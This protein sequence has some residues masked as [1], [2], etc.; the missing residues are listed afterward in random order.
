MEA[1]DV[2]LD[3]PRRGAFQSTDLE[4]ILRSRG[5]DTVIISGIATR[6]CCETTAREAVPRDFQVFFLSDGTAMADMPG[7]S[8]AELQKATLATLGFLFAQVLTDEMM[9]KI[10]HPAHRCGLKRRTCTRRR[11]AGWNRF[12][13][14]R[15]ATLWIC[16]PSPCVAR[17]G[18]EPRSSARCFVAA[19]TC[20]GV[21]SSVARDGP[22]RL[23]QG[24]FASKRSTLARDAARVPDD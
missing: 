21:G 13:D 10:R 15:S 18:E 3:K 5:I 8:A 23:S 14:R 2:L 11:L 22:I 4:L 16:A 7:A 20:T 6:V 24:V 19:L 9:Q 1:R 17:G 12:A